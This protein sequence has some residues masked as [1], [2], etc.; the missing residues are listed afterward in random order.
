MKR[1]TYIHLFLFMIFVGLTTVACEEEEAIGVAC[2]TLEDCILGQQCIDGFCEDSADSGDT[3][4]DTGNSANSVDTGNSADSAD[5]GNSVDDSDTANTGNSVDDSDTANTGNSGDGSDT[6]DSADSVDDGDSADTGST[7]GNSAVETGEACE[8]SDTKNCTLIAAGGYSGGIA[9][10]ATNCLSW[11]VANCTCPAGSDKNGAGICEVLCGNGTVDGDETCEPSDTKECTTFSG[12]GFE[13][14]TATCESDCTA[15]DKTSCACPEN[16]VIDGDGNCVEN[17]E[18]TLGTDNCDI[19]ATCTDTPDSFTCACKDYYDGD[20]TNCTFC[21]TDGQ[22]KSDCTACDVATPK[23]KTNGATTA[24]VECLT[25][26]DCTSPQTCN[27]SNQCIDPPS[28]CEYRIYVECIDESDTWPIYTKVYDNGTRIVDENFWAN[29]DGDYEN[30]YFTV[31][32]GH[33]I[34][35]DFSGTTNIYKDKIYN[36]H[37]SIIDESSYWGGTDDYNFT[38]NCN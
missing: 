34:E 26:T 36:S 6:A 11:D 23:C 22:C 12:A 1:L 29:W 33:S 4:G 15:W 31:T 37:G 9:D 21:N 2:I 25:T 27:T 5:T 32:H 7:C 18:C 16:L 35:V 8:L 24:C 20:G 13:S 14:G 17:N 28:T 30:Y 19:N 38:A 3:S 10:C